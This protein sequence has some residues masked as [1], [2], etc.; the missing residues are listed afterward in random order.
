MDILISKT[1]DSSV[2]C[3]AEQTC[4]IDEEIYDQ[5]IEEFQRMGARLLTDTQTTALAARSFTDEGKVQLDV[6][7]QSCVNLAGLAGFEAVRRG[8]GA[9]RPAPDGPR[10]PR[11]ASV[12]R[13]EADAGARRGALAVGRTRD[14][15]VRA[16]HRARRPRPHLGRLRDRRRSDRSLH[17]GDPNGADPRQ[18]ADRGRSPGRHLQL[19]DPDLLA[20][21][22]HVGRLEHDRQRQLPKP[23]E[24]QDRVAAADAVPVV[25]GSLG[26]VLQPRRARQP[27]P[28]RRLATDDRHR[29]SDRGPGRRRGGASLPRPPA[30][31]TCSPGSSRSRPRR[32]SA[33]E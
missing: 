7:G 31:C 30:P 29:R 1:F 12:H 32:R 18:R 20:R 26:H 15:C 3:P 13:R 8:Q 24:H 19:D 6:L 16:G 10:R 17:A 22:R 5:V 28:A 9:A 27:A 11:G 2:I 25:P 14:P 4:V 21:L 33:P 23:A